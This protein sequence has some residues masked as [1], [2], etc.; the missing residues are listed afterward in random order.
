MLTK[1][2][3]QL[4]AV[5][6]TQYGI[7][8]CVLTEHNGLEQARIDFETKPDSIWMGGK[9]KEFLHKV[10]KERLLKEDAYFTKHPKQADV[11]NQRWSD[12]CDDCVNFAVLASVLYGTPV[13]LVHPSRYGTVLQ[14]QTPNGTRGEKPTLFADIPVLY[15]N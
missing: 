6:M 12:F 1:V 5:S 15:P 11:R 7:N 8:M 14:N 10:L 9:G 2:Q 13:H 4:S 3:K